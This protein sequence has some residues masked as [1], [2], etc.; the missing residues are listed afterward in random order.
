VLWLAEGFD[1]FVDGTTIHTGK[2]YVYNRLVLD[3]S[4]TDNFSIT[5][6][7]RHDSKALVVSPGSAQFRLIS[8]TGLFGT[9][10]IAFAIKRTNNGS[11]GPT[12]LKFVSS[13]GINSHLEFRFYGSSG[14]D[15]AVI[16]ADGSS[17][18]A[19]D[20]F[21]LNSWVWLSLVIS[22]F[23]VGYV[24]VLN[25]SLSEILQQN[26]DTRYGND[27]SVKDIRFVPGPI[28]YHLDDLF[29]AD[30]SGDNWNG[31]IPDFEIHKFDVRGFRAGS[32]GFADANYTAVTTADDDSSYTTDQIL[33]TNYVIADKLDTFGM[34]NIRGIAINSRYKVNDSTI[35]AITHKVYDGSSFFP[36]DGA[37]WSQGTGS[38][39]DY[40]SYQ[41]IAPKNPVNNLNWTFGSIDN[42][43]IV[44]ES[45][46]LSTN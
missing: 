39:T 33:G 32:Q 19:S 1:D 4:N 14:S 5:N 36:I 22:F 17:T 38:P 46:L 42:M 12:F 37:N 18:T 3:P 30:S 11:G 23:D 2:S 24:Y 40:R 41:S 10:F 21:P 45:R 31:P 13:N 25:G 6:D 28:T 43:A 35:R 34:T 29:I 20:V 16:F 27:S 26:G 9:I 7:G 15:L 44:F 8:S